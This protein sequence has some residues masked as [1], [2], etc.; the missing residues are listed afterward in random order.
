MPSCVCVLTYFME[1][2]EFQVCI[3]SLLSQSNI[4]K[5]KK[6]ISEYQIQA[7][8]CVKEISVNI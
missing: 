4:V 5:I 1:I 8:E 7:W 6:S 3:F 2:W